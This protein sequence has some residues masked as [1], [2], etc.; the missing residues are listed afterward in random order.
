VAQWRGGAAR[1]NLEGVGGLDHVLYH[2]VHVLAPP[3]PP[4]ARHRARLGTST[5]PDSTPA[6]AGAGAGLGEEELGEAADKLLALLP[7]PV[8]AAAAAAR[9]RRR[10]VLRARVVLARARACG[11]PRVGGCPAKAGGGLGAR[12]HPS[13]RDSA[14]GPT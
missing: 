14:G 12:R 11:A 13:R 8:A 7:L 4:R 9:A 3:L 6:G 5:R 2:R 10:P 1:G